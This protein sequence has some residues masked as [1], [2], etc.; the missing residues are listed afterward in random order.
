MALHA[1]PP[2][3][4]MHDALIIGGVGTALLALGLLTI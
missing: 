3:S 1:L 4:L 2:L